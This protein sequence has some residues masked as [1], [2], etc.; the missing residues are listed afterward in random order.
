MS[1]TVFAITNQTSNLGYSNSIK[2]LAEENKNGKV[3]NFDLGNFDKSVFEEELSK[4]SK[5]SQ[6]LLLT[7]AAFDTAFLNDISKKFPNTKIVLTS[8]KFYDNDLS[9]IS[10][11]S[12]VM[13]EKAIN[14]YKE[15]FPNTNITGYNAELVASPSKEDMENR[16]N[17]FK[18]LNPTV[19]EEIETTLTNNKTN[20]F[21]VGGRVSLP[22]GGFKE[23]TPEIFTDIAKNIVKSG[24]P[25]IVTFH[26]LR[27]FTKG[28][29]S[30]DFAPYLAFEETIKNYLQ[31]KQKV[32]ILTKEAK[33]NNQRKSVAKV[34]EKNQ[35]SYF[36]INESKFG[37]A[38]YYFLLNEVVKNKFILRATVEQMN[39]IPE[40]L[41]LGADVG[42]FIP[43]IWDLHVQSN[44]DTYGSLF[45]NYFKTGEPLLTQSQA[46]KKL[47]NEAD[48][49]NILL[50]KGFER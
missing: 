11:I 47:L 18:K 23:N 8:D 44:L 1:I 30:N 29:N 26:G 42:K 32:I 3:L 22:D 27:S 9:N 25:T 40:A 28:D 14:K 2:S 6:T 36:S 33:S 15:K 37:A 48:L 34:F 12:L 35:T 38:E 45:E 7:S 41:T 49:N 10:K 20:V 21:F 31:P 19:A 50:S 46:F 5:T 13:P 4:A 39:F 43:C 17:D 16:A 24:N